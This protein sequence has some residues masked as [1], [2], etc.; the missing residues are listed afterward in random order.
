MIHKTNSENNTAKTWE[1]IYHN[2]NR[3]LILEETSFILKRL[4]NEM[5]KTFPQKS[6]GILYELGSLNSKHVRQNI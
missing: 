4:A 3:C 5:N 1:I 6:R 2:K